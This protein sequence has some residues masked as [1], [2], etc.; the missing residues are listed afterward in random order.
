MKT[1][2]KSTTNVSPVR[3]LFILYLLKLHVLALVVIEDFFLL[4]L[5]SG[6]L[7]RAGGL[8]EMA[9]GALFPEAEQRLDNVCKNSQSEHD[10]KNEYD[11][12]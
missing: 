11:E 1:G 7:F 9:V 5:G 6:R 4:C 2:Y 3:F 8:S 12:E 10:E